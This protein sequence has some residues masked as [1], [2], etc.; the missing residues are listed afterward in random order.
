MTKKEMVLTIARAKCNAFYKLQS[1]ISDFGYFDELTRC[2]LAY[3][4]ALDDLCISLGIDAW[5]IF[6]KAR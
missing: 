6:E 5:E 1:S 3:W 4:K 2:D